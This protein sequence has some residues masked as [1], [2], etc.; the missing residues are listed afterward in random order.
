MSE[1]VFKLPDLGEGM[2]EAEIVE[3]HVKPG[4]SV[5]EGDIIADVMTDKANIEVPA[6]VS[7]TILRTSGEP[8][9]LIAVGAE[10]AAFTTEGEVGVAD[11]PVAETPEP[12]PPANRQ[13]HPNQRPPRRRV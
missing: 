3:W 12:A 7:G 11:A 13:R 5:A 6:P 9:D 1:F 4:D 2:V 10:L 8:G